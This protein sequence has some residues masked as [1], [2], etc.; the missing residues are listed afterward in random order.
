MIEKINPLVENESVMKLYF[1][2]SQIS[3]VSER[4][5]MKISDVLS[6][7][8]GFIKSILA[9]VGFIT[10]YHNQASMKIKL[11]NKIYNT[12]LT[13]LNRAT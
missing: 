9:I 8:G 5:F 3:E 6:Y 7:L 10:F 13:G 11:V 2:S 4:N 12:T 1:R